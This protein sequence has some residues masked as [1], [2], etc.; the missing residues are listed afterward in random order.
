LLFRILDTQI[1]ILYSELAPDLIQVISRVFMEE[2]LKKL[3]ELF[4]ANKDDDF[5]ETLVRIK[6]NNEDPHD[7]IQKL[8]L[9]ADQK[10]LEQLESLAYKF[11]LIMALPYLKSAINSNDLDL[12]FTTCRQI[13]IPSESY[14]ETYQRC[15]K[16]HAQFFTVHEEQDSLKSA[17]QFIAQANSIEG[18]I[19]HIRDEQSLFK[20]ILANTPEDDD[21]ALLNV[22]FDSYFNPIFFNPFSLDIKDEYIKMFRLAINEVKK[23]SDLDTTL[24]TKYEQIF[25]KKICEDFSKKVIKFLEGKRYTQLGDL[26]SH[27]NKDGFDFRELFERSLKH[28]STPNILSSLHQII[29][30]YDKII[31]FRSDSQGLT[32]LNIILVSIFAERKLRGSEKKSPKFIHE[33]LKEHALPCPI[34]IDPFNHTFYILLVLALLEQTSQPI[35]DKKVIPTVMVNKNESNAKKIALTVTPTEEENY[36]D[37]IE[38]HIKYSG[39]RGLMGLL[40]Y[41]DLPGPAKNQHAS[42]GQE[43]FKTNLIP[44]SYIHDIG[45]ESSVKKELSFET[46]LRIIGDISCGLE[47]MHAN[48][49]VHADIKLENLLYGEDDDGH[50]RAVITDYGLTYNDK[51]EHPIW[52]GFWYGTIFYTPPEFLEDLQGRHDGKAADLYALGCCIYEL[53]IGVLPWYEELSQLDDS[54]NKEIKDI[55]IKDPTPENRNRYIETFDHNLLEKALLKQKEIS[56][57]IKKLLQ[58]KTKGPWSKQDELRLWILFLMQPDPFERPTATQLKKAISCLIENI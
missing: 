12:F 37:E 21:E 41:K 51:T 52:V 17:A 56:N 45:A 27:V 39:K 10:T 22:E 44:Y 23:E 58:R 2:N 18:F 26:L 49:E 38:K 14:R 33:N 43:F 13:K 1:F 8:G 48:H 15:Q 35:G 42:I 4:Q 32:S 7:Y 53:S 55:Y 29:S 57:E 6:I 30:F 31:P 25:E 20:E 46:L 36:K 3:K 50:V 5:I 54:A 40:F 47:T 28:T 24:L 16:A 9:D 11:N 19:S 34:I